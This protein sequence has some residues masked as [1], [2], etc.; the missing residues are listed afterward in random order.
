MKLLWLCILALSPI[1][2]A[3]AIPDIATL[4]HD[5]EHNQKASEDLRKHY[6]YRATTRTEETDNKGNIKKVETSVSEIFTRKGVIVSR[7]IEKDGKPLSEKDARKEEECIEKDV[8]K[9]IKKREKLQAEGKHTNGN[10]EDVLTISRILELGTFTNPRR[11]TFKGRPAIVV[12]YAGDRNAKTRNR[13]E[14]V[15]KLLA[16]T[17]WI[18]EQ[19]RA[20]V[21][22][23]GHV[24]DNFHVGGGLLVNVHEGFRFSFEQTYVNNEV[25]LPS[26]VEG[27][28]S[29]RIFLFFKIQGRQRTTFSKY[30]KFSAS[31]TI[32]PGVTEVKD[33][34]AEE[35]APQK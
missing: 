23:E 26:V 32:L 33:A 31:A 30:R 9:A 34:P 6:F 4:M 29:A 20:L 2:K 27:E 21:R 10:G 12:D 1:S 15:F 35:T 25:W 13:F 7:L 17:I 28:G 18:D 14:D 24:T 22:G 16:G 5:V 11:E 8:E 3:Q 19:T